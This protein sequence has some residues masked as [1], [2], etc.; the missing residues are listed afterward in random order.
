MQDEKEEHSLE[1]LD[2][3]VSTLSASMGKL[4]EAFPAVAGKMKQQ[5]AAGLLP[6]E[7]A[8]NRKA[9]EIAGA[10]LPD[11]SGKQQHQEDGKKEIVGENSFKK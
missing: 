7:E 3:I 2:T 9:T 5:K 4:Q 1:A 6:G 8:K 11:L 10:A